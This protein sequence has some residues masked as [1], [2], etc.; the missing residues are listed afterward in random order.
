[1]T[2]HKTARIFLLL[3]VAGVSQ[4]AAVL[5]TGGFTCANTPTPAS[6]PDC[7]VEALPVAGEIQ[8]VKFYLNESFLSPGASADLVFST[9][10]TLTGDTGVA[11]GANMTV[12]W[13]FTL[14]SSTITSASIE[15]TILDTN[16]VYD[17]TAPVNGG[18]NTGTENATFLHPM[19]LGD[20]VTVQLTLLVNVVASTGVNVTIPS[21][22]LDFNVAAPESGTV[23]LLAAGMATLF[24]LRRRNSDAPLR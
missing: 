19:S 22:S 7:A 15:F 6:G 17:I 20:T 16:V 4:A 2:H 14:N 1:V 18:L 12:G 23:G 8:G 13:D 21:S 5:P 24:L 9:T 3:A 10:G 11:E